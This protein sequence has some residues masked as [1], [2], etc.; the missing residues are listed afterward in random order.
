M[1]EN[2][3]I[4]CTHQK[5]RHVPSERLVIIGIASVVTAAV[6]VFLAVSISSSSSRPSSSSSS[7]TVLIDNVSPTQLTMMPPKSKRKHVVRPAMHGLSLR[8]ASFGTYSGSLVTKWICV[9]WTHLQG[10]PNIVFEE[11]EEEDDEEDDRSNCKR[12][13]LQMSP[14]YDFVLF[15]GFLNVLG[16]RPFSCNPSLLFV[17]YRSLNSGRVIPLP[18]RVP[19]SACHVMYVFRVFLCPQRSS[20]PSS[21]RPHCSSSHCSSAH[22]SCS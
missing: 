17:S 11:E 1:K 7:P 5:S 2:Q 13:E 3:R 4:N 10:F 18:S 20:S 9:H 12:N 16:A 6:V 15:Y 19:S 14:L 22:C 21:S 8:A